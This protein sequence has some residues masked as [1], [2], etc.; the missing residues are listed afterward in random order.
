LKVAEP[1]ES[2]TIDITDFL[3]GSPKARL[4]TARTDC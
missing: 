2:V 1:V 4:V 3:L